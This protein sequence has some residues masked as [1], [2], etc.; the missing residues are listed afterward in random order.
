MKSERRQCK[1]SSRHWNFRKCCTKYRFR[2]DRAFW[3]EQFSLHVAILVLRNIDTFGDTNM[4]PWEIARMIFLQEEIQSGYAF[5]GRDYIILFLQKISIDNFKAL[6]NA[7]DGNLSRVATLVDKGFNPE[8]ILQHPHLIRTS[9]IIGTVREAGFT[10]EQILENIDDLIEISGN[11][12]IWRQEWKQK[13][14]LPALKAG[15]T[16]KE[17]A[18]I[19][20]AK[21]IQ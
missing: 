8:Q 9:P 7:L 16:F 21:D 10:T 17:V 11:A 12:V 18:E 2:H 1:C 4:S 15:I 3:K 19:I 14:L 13:S 5:H 20:Q 6:Y